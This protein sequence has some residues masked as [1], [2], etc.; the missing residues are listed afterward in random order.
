MHTE[1]WFQNSIV[2]H[3]LGNRG[4]GGAVVLKWVLT[5]IYRVSKLYTYFNGEC[6]L[7]YL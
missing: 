6:V 5:G 3:H 2:L 7:K 1:Y 4:V